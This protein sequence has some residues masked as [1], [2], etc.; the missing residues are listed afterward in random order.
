MNRIFG[1]MPDD[2]I[3]KEKHYKDCRSLPITI[4]AGPNGW[5]IIY[6]D[7]SSHWYDE[8]NTTDENFTNAFEIAESELGTLTEIEYET[9]GEA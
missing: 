7:G 5:T 8:Q 4:Q 9:H 6:S 3:E 1:V 2:E